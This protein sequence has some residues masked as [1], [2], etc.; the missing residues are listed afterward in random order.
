MLQGTQIW[1]VDH[2]FGDLCSACHGGDPGA[3]LQD[4]AHLGLRMPLADPAVSCAGCHAADAA[5]RA[6]R[7]RAVIIPAADTPVPPVQAA[8]AARGLSLANRLLA[9]LAAL[10]ALALYVVVRRELATERIPLLTW[11]RAKTWSPYTAGGL[12][13]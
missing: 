13:G 9:G 7:Y 8:S 6:E 3:A 10:L 11:L 1:H 5:Q 12:L 2:G 4:Q